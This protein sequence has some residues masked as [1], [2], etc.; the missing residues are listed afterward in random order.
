MISREREH[1]IPSL[2]FPFGLEQDRIRGTL[3]LVLSF[4][5]PPRNPNDVLFA[6]HQPLKK[7]RDGVDVPADDPEMTWRRAFFVQP[8]ECPG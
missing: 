4:S 3:S 2:S 7:I 1:F 6:H 8:L 5:S